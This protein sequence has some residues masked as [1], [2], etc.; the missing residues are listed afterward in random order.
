MYANAT[1]RPV[2]EASH[3]GVVHVRPYVCLAE[4]SCPRR[5]VVT[6]SLLHVGSR[7]VS[8]CVSLLNSNS[9]HRASVCAD[10]PYQ[11]KAANNRATNLRDVLRPSTV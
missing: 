6:D 5:L 10:A 11:Y 4:L 3:F 8:V 2:L 7:C 9:F 1:I